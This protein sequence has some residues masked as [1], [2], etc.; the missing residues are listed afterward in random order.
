MLIFVLTFFLI[1]GTRCSS[2]TI[3]LILTIFIVGTISGFGY[4]RENVP[5]ASRRDSMS[6]I[7]RSDCTYLTAPSTITSLSAL[8]TP[9]V[10]TVQNQNYLPSNSV[11]K[12]YAYMAFIYNEFKNSSGV[13]GGTFI[14]DDSILTSASCVYK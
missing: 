4:I 2:T 5:F 6:T 13:C 3:A 9:D 7:S 10:S 14:S 12:K 8:H 1:V 11:H